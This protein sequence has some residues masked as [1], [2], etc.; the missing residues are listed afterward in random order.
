MGTINLAL[1]MVWKL[2]FGLYDYDSMFC[3][4][5]VIDRISQNIESNCYYVSGGHCKS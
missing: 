4:A 3:P 1:N 2:T 5:D